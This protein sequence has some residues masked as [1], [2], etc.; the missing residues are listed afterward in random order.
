MNMLKKIIVL[1][2]VLS[3]VGALAAEELPKPVA[4]MECLVGTWKGSGSFVMGKDKAKLEA[5]WSCRRTSS[6][7][8][9]LC[10]LRATGIPGMAVYDETDLMGFEPNTGTYHWYSVTNAGE[11]HDHVAKAGPGNPL[12]FVFDGTQEGKAFREVIDL[13]LASDGKSLSGRSESFVGGASTGLI[14]LALR[15]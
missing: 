1:A 4:D 2:S 10:T 5:T 9:L 8:G 13:D 6:R 3:P 15:K 12:R 14:E 7:F 11:T